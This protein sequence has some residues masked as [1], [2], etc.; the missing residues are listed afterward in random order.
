MTD[1]CHVMF[2]IITLTKMNSE[3]NRQM[4]GCLPIGRIVADSLANYIMRGCG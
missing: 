3:Q 1:K 2:A 4:P